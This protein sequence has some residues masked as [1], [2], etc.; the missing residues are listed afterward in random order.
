MRNTEAPRPW[1]GSG[2]PDSDRG[3]DPDDMPCGLRPSNKSR[4]SATASRR[5]RDIAEILGPDIERALARVGSKGGYL[6]S[7]LAMSAP[8]VV[9][10]DILAAF[11]TL[12]R[13]LVDMAAPFGG[14]VAVRPHPEGL[15]E[16]EWSDGERVVIGDPAK[17]EDVAEA[18]AGLIRKELPLS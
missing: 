18:I 12:V 10:H 17:T 9:V 1:V 7:Y 16:L 8:A 11:Q 14:F 6:A 3:Y 2:E 15:V 5:K 13:G 4:S